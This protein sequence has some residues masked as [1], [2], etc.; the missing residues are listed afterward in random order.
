MKIIFLTHSSDQ[1]HRFR[2][3]QYFPSLTDQGI[4]PKWQPLPGSLKDRF[5]IYR[6]LP[7]FDV[8]CIQRRLLAPLE[9][10]WIQ[11]K[12]K[13]IVFDLDD[14]IMYRSS[15]SPYP[16]SFSRSFKFKWMVK[17][18]DIVIAGNRFLK[19]EVLKVDRNKKVILIPTSIDLTLYPKKKVV[20]GGTD[21]VLGWIG[22]KG[23]IKY[24]KKLEP[25][26]ETLIKRFARLKLK[27]VSDDFYR[28]P[29]IPVIEK[30]WRLEDENDDLIS[31]D[32]GLMP[33]GE[34]LWS[35]GKCGLKIVQYLSVGVPVV[36]T[37]VGINCDI[38]VNGENG[39]WATTDQEWVDRL[40][41]L[42]QNQELR[43]QMGVKGIETI[44]KG[45]SLGVTSEKFLQAIQSLTG[46]ASGMVE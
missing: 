1:G 10:F 40:S 32:I 29:S 44:E 5:S 17:G 11:R 37:P 2:V 6:Q 20:S 19:D 22:T 16:H 33:L 45:Y 46:K 9:L 27:I 41:T 14:A 25:V 3:E 26:F 35:K 18:S 24:L 31:F 7:Q 4:E 30:P 43:R 12:S 23:N 13:K 28:S 38:V 39:F 42:I 21:I 36:C 34:D 8:V 15:S